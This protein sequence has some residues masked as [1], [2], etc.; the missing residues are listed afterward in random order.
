MIAASLVRVE[1]W[2][3]HLIPAGVTLVLFVVELL[4]WAGHDI[5]PVPS[6]MLIAIFYWSVRVPA[7]CPPLFALALGLCA[8]LL[9]MTPLGSQGC[10][11]LV[12]S[13]LAR[14][15]AKRLGQQSFI[16]LWSL[17]ALVMLGQSL[18]LWIGELVLASTTLPPINLLTRA[19]LTVALFPVVAR[20]LLL[21]AQKLANEAVL[22]D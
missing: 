9:E 5:I 16:T 6:L 11:A 18:F 2:T 10:V 19:L 20:L 14:F 1:S 13:L 15:K 21:P 3:R 22:V 4:P 8:D 17:F 7:L 12:I